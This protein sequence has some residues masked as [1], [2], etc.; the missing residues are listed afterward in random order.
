MSNMPLSN[1]QFDLY[2]NNADLI[3]KGAEKCVNYSKEYGIRQLKEQDYEELMDCFVAE[4]ND[5]VVKE[6]RR[7]PKCNRK[8]ISK[9]A[10]R[11]Y[12]DYI[13]LAHKL[14]NL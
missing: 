14:M 3:I 1:R 11:Y 4:I 8:I 6:I 12:L 10:N 7:N 2:V 13:Q 5:L 9:I